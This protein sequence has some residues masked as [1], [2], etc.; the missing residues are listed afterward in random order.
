MALEVWKDPE[1]LGGFILCVVTIPICCLAT[2]LRFAASKK[3]T[4]SA[5][6][7]SWL[8]LAALVF[9]LVYTLMFLYRS[10]R[11]SFYPACLVRSNPLAD[12]PLLDSSDGTKW[13]RPA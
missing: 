7:E 3:T 10:S 8:S 9:F 12:F 1:Q 11:L 6:L 4:G 2:G 5:N 13:P